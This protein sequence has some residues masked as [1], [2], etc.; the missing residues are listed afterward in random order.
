[1]IAR[2]SRKPAEQTNRRTSQSVRPLHKALGVSRNL[3][4]CIVCSYFGFACSTM[5]ASFRNR[6]L[7]GQDPLACVVETRQPHQKASRC[8]GRSYLPS[9]H[10]PTRRYAHLR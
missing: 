1:M 5:Q 6:F 4:V 9:R 10:Q 2:V 7:S 8:L 3:E